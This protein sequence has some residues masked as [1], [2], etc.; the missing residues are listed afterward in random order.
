MGIPP[1]AFVVGIVARMQRHRHY[2]DLFEAV[3]RLAV[4]NVRVIVVGRGTRQEE[5]GREPV[6]RL[7]LEGRVHFVGYVQG[8]DYVGILNAFDV[9][10]FLV[11]GSDGT[12]RA[13]RE[14]M[15]MGK[16]PVVAARGM[17]AE[18]VEDGKEGF[19]VDGSVEGLAEAL[20]RLA[21]N[22]ALARGLGRAA[23]ER[24][25]LRYSLEAQARE[26]HA[27][28]ANLLADARGSKR[29]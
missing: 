6:R 14:A 2:D 12:C 10:V 17:L 5:V 26:V 9:M 27:V 28:Y 19:V 25:V 8:E 20:L 15:A 3:R 7:G 4:E 16:P 23:R 13:V 1:E 21:K 11:P 29:L 18:I 24:A 22:R